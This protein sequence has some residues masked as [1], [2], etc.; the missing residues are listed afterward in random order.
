MLPGCTPEEKQESDDDD[1]HELYFQ[2]ITK[3]VH[4][5]ILS[6]KPNIN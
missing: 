6:V 4:R 5:N 2:E 3:F 1:A